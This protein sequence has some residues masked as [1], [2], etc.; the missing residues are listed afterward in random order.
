MDTG[1]VPQVFP[2]HERDRLPDK[3]HR[4]PMS[5]LEV[6]KNHAIVVKG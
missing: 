4:V 6:V 3:P 5:G 2:A 1:E